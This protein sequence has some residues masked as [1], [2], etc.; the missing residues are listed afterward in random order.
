MLTSILAKVQLTTT[1][2]ISAA[3]V[4]GVSGTGSV[5][6][7]TVSTGTGSGTLRLDI[8]ASATITDVAGNPLS[9]LPYSGGEAYH[10]NKGYKLFLPLLKR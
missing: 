7:V 6:T 2:N 1:G 4:T 10:V 8:P 3:S 5:Y 9:G